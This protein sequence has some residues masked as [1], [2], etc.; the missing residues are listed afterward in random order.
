MTDDQAARMCRSIHNALAAVAPV[1]SVALSPGNVGPAVV[2]YARTATAQQLSAAAQI[3]STWDYT[4]RVPLS[5]AEMLAA[6]QALTTQQQTAVFQAAAAAVL[7][8][9]PTVAQANGITPDKTI[10]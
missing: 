5:Q 2:Q 4:P 9:N 6:V 7:I 8:V 3:L 1:D 10:S